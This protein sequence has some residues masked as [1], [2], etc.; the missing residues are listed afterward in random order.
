AGKIDPAARPPTAC[1][2]DSIIASV[3]NPQPMTPVELGS[4]WS[5]FTASKCATSAQTRSLS[6]TPPGA[7]TFEILLFTIM[8][9]N[10]GADK[11]FRPTITGAPGKALR[12]NTAPK[13]AVG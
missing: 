5:D 8:A 12:V 10:A 3:G 4:T 7:Q 2:S 6:S 13:S 1:G 11:R 9:L